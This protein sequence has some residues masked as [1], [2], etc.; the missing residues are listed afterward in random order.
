MSTTTDI[1]NKAV[2]GAVWATLDRF[3]TMGIQFIVNLILARLLVPEYFG[4]I[5]MIAIFIVVSQTL[6][7]GGFTSA[8]IQKKSPTQAD[9]STIFYWSTALST[10]LYIILFISAPL[11]ADFYRTPLLT[12]VIR[13]I[14]ITL[15][16]SAINAIFI[17]RLRKSLSFGIIAATN[18]LSYT[19]SGAVSITM[20]FYGCGIWCLIVMQIGSNACSILMLSIITR[21][22]PTMCFSKESFKELFSFGGYILAANILQ[23]ICQNIQGLIIGRLFSATQMGYYSQAYK[24]DQVTSYSL[25]YIIVQVMYPVYSSIQDNLERLRKMLMM[26]IRVIS[27]LIFP[28]LGLL[29]ITSYTLITTIYGMKWAPCAPYFSILCIGGFFACL[30]NINFYAVAAVGRSRQLFLWSFYKWGFLLSALFAGAYFGMYGILWAMVAS[31]LNIYIVNASLAARYVGL[32]LFSQIF[33]LLPA[34]V[35]ISLAGLSA[36]VIKSTVSDNPLIYVL[37]FILSYIVSSL[38]FNRISVTESLT[39]I[40]KIIKRK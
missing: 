32:N 34:T 7:D 31:N 8:L 18:V 39:I 33:T 24:L 21:W 20:A 15:P 14:G 2:R 12:P 16:L 4:I 9:Y 23:S 10:F 3:G 29:A 19:I 38:L 37:I 22:H 13:V 11:I 35:C 28:I 25:P 1:S 26:N 40:K 17:A 27:F 5:G 6:I 30:Q 36:W